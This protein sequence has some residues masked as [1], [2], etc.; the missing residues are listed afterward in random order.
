M[1]QQSSQKPVA[2]IT[3]ASSGIGE[4]TAR[5]FAAGG[6]R[7]VAV[8]RRQERLNQLAKE[9]SATTDV[10]T[11]S[12]DVT[13][14]NAS[15]RSVDAAMS[16]FGRLDCLINNAGV[17]KSAPLDQTSDE[18]WDENVVLSMTAPFRFS[19]EALHVMRPGSSILFVGSVF[20]I[21]G[22]MNGGV[23][24]AVKAGQIGLMHALA[25][26]FGAKGIRS[27]VVAPGV[28]KTDMTKDFWDAPAFRR[29]NQ[30]MTPSDREC[31]SDDV[32]NMLYYLASEH[33]GFING[34]TIVLD[35]G[36]TTTK[37]LCHEALVAERVKR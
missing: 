11:V 1:T 30:E 24:C 14:K 29:V 4:T 22:G 33:G 23:Y 27:N 12:A 21:L 32:A 2:L 13:E 37:Y 3:G 6:Y 25:L 16:R 31:T 36:W 26:E 34:Q 35:G 17:F 5:R 15:K 9:L 20:G 7:I 8:A 10:E 28:V 19:R 18:L